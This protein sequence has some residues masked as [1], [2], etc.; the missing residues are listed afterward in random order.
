MTKKEL[1]TPYIREK[2]AYFR[3]RKAGNKMLITNDAG[4]YALLNS[5]AYKKFLAGSL[6]ANSAEHK[7]L[8]KQG[9]I[10]DALDFQ[11]LIKKYGQ[12]NY[13]LKQGPSLHIIVVTLRCNHKCLYCHASAGPENNEGLDMAIDTAKMTVDT[14]FRT[15]AQNIT[16]EF[17]GGEPLL[18]WGVI[19]FIIEYSKEK[20]KIDNKNLQISLV[21]NFSLMD[22]KKL[23]FL[24]KNKV[25]LCTSLD[26]P[27]EIHNKNR[28]YSA[29]NSHKNVI[30]WLKKSDDL[31]KKKYDICRP[32][33]LTTITKYSLPHS[34]A[35]IDQ[36]VSLGLP[37]IYLRPLNPFGVAK[38]TWEQIGYSIDDFIKFYKKS[39]NYII[40]L[41]LKGKPIQ[42]ALAVTFLTKILTDRDPNHMDYRSPCGAGIGQIAYNYNGDV[43]TCDEGRMFGRIGD[44]IFKMGNVKENSY[45]ELMN[46]EVVK[47]MCIASCLEAIPG[48]SDCAH[49]PYCGV[50]P[51]YNYSEQGSIFGQMST[52][53]RCKINM[54]VFDYLFEKMQNKKIE[55]IFQKW[56]GAN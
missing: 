4:G 49:K 55:E 46:S 54:A 51:V 35:I 47:S 16:I 22:D 50:C 37:K 3:E 21:S 2:V 10:R 12:K 17:Q 9:F 33:A 15:T 32:G 45:Q 6:A 28:F 24:V 18:N 39:L 14:I 7:S 31:Y 53:G 36:Y 34:K 8:Q 29:G 5:A 30:T 42:E 11:A 52:N 38:K 20:E 48:C 27:E 25:S 26:G 44:D 1:G 43:Y 40:S 23:N 41:N 19:K 13:F 56:V